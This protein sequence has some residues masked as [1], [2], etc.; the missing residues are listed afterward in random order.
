MHSQVLDHIVDISWAWTKLIILKV[1]FTQNKH[2]LK[3]PFSPQAIQYTGTPK[4]IDYHE[5]GQY[6]LLLISESEPHIDSLHIE[7]NISSLYFLK[8]WWLCRINE[9]PIFSVSEY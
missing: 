7:W 8:C 6:F 9:N 2:V 3:M 1:Q 5:K 4:K